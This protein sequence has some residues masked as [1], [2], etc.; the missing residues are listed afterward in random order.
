[1]AER[2]CAAAAVVALLAFAALAQMVARS[3]ELWPIDRA[4]VR[5]RGQHVL[6]ARAFTKTGR[7]GFLFAASLLLFAGAYLLH[8]QLRDVVVIVAAQLLSQGAVEA[9]KRE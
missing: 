4:S 7:N 1:M 6:L 8:V 5:L 2:W 9:M 3:T